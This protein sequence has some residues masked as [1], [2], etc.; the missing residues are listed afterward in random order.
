[1]LEKKLTSVVWQGQATGERELE[2][3]L[4]IDLPEVVS[5][6]LPLHAVITQCILISNIDQLQELEEPMHCLL[7][8]WLE[9][10]LVFDCPSHIA[11]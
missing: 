8:V 6:M 2:Q 4:N 5:S 10:F 7:F 3:G 9:G 11:A 1:M